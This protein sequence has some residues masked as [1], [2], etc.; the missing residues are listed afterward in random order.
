MSGIAVAVGGGAALLGGYLQGQA[1]QG[2]ADTQAGAARY[3]ADVQQ[4]IYNQQR[5]DQ[6]PWRAAGATAL[7]QMQDPSFQQTFNMSNF[8]ADPG[9]QFRM[10]EGQKALERSAAA[11][12]GL[13]SGG[14]LKALT[15]YSQGV[16]S[17][18]YNNAYNRFNNDQ[19]NRFNRLASLS[20]NGQ[21]ANSQLGA[22]GQNYA[23]QVG[24]AATGAANAQAA[25]QIGQA[26]AM[27]NAL[28]QGTNTWMGYQMMNRLMPQT[29]S[30]S[31]AYASSYPS[32][33]P[34]GGGGYLGDYTLNE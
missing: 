7:Q 27:S 6:A 23:N 14:T 26:N 15:R 9:Y 2:A 1:A 30:P 5:S 4:N 28:S 24:Q 3:A 20:G 25:G 33:A 12:G 17:D 19:T 16:A 29:N 31:A 22:A 21:T 32:S 13:Q 34:S 10:D 18:E 8:T 11:K